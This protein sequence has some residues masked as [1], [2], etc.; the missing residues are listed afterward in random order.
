MHYML[1]TEAKS[2]NVTGVL[3]DNKNA[4]GLYNSSARA[5]LITLEKLNEGFDGILAIELSTDDYDT[6]LYLEFRCNVT[7]TMDTS[8]SKDVTVIARVNERLSGGKLYTREYQLRVKLVNN[9]LGIGEAGHITGWQKI[10]IT[11]RE[12]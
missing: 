9:V 6:Q 2:P 3:Y 7:V 11:A 12:K 10:K 4:S 1:L 5:S 8:I